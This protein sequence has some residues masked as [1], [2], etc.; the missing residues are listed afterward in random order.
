MPQNNR[1]D[2]SARAARWRRGWGRVGFRP[3]LEGLEARVA[4]ADGGLDPSFGDGGKL[5]LDLGDAAAS[6]QA[7]AVQQ[8]GK[9]VVAGN[10]TRSGGIFLSRLE[11]DGTPDLSF[12]AG[13]TRTLDS[14]DFRSATV[15]TVLLQADG[16]IVVVGSSSTG[17]GLIGATRTVVAARFSRSGA[18]DPTFGVGGMVALALDDLATVGGAT[19]QDDGKI[20]IAGQVRVSGNNAHATDTVVVRLNAN[21]SLDPSFDDDG[22]RVVDYGI[23][24]TAAAVLVQRDGK[25]VVG[26]SVREPGVFLGGGTNSIA[27]A[28]LGP[29]GA[30]DPSFSGDGLLVIEETANSMSGSSATGL[31]LQGD[32]KILVA[33]VSKGPSSSIQSAFTA[34]RVLGDGRLDRSFSGDGIQ[35]VEFSGFNPTPT[36]LAIQG[37][38]RI[39]L[40]GYTS[41]A[42]LGALGGDFAVARLTANGQLDSSFHEDG[43]QT[44]AFDLSP[45]LGSTNSEDAGQA[46]AIQPD[47]R[48][49]LAGY[50]TVQANAQAALARLLSAA[51]NVPTPTPPPPNPPTPPPPP[52]PPP[53]PPGGTLPGP[54]GLGT[55]GSLYGGDY[56]GDGLPDLAL[57]SLDDSGTGRFHLRLST[58]GG[59]RVGVLGRA[60]D[61][62]VVGDFDGDGKSDL[63][64]FDSLYDGDGD[65][66]AESGA[67]KIIASMT[68]E[69]VVIPFGAPGELDRPAPADYDGDGVTDL[70]V[71]RPESDLIPGAAEWFVRRSRD[72]ALRVQFGAAAGVDLPVPADYDGDG[73]AD[74]ATFRPVPHPLDVQQGAAQWF[75][76]PSAPNPGWV[77]TRGAFATAF[78]A[79]SGTDQP[80]VADFDGDGRA[81]IAAFRSVSD[82][83]SGR[84][85]WFILPA[86]SGPNGG[87]R[88]TFGD[89]GAL[90]APAD[91]DGDGV[92]ELAIHDP[93]TGRWR[94]RSLSSAVDRPL[95]FGTAG[96]VVVPVLSPLASRLLATERDRG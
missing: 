79:P 34:L 50:A 96:R 38:G 75:V 29:S 59:T 62:P 28:R 33:G 51:P 18:P 67:W 60:G 71:F 5:L 86:A 19:L 7:L 20:V 13:G 94:F 91:Y 2:R 85:D 43:K 11:P 55:D 69:L 35:H 53:S 1:R 26:G 15:S 46:L 41:I 42:P 3:V 8:D 70:A 39:V 64:V 56:D 93:T 87:V 9:V 37:D 63:A 65:G 36:G 48:I 17:G 81:D 10:F 27:L 73:I 54:F 78:G 16:R 32:G 40:G 57:F 58:T 12:A 66:E 47:G 68:G 31:A 82:L 80:V 44:V 45:M 90:A 89:A 24:S 84:A 25:I 49:V 83:A 52:I 72:G 76:L 74:L 92:A 95:S 14:G 6:A 30:L 61:V 77:T 23:Q 4:L 22:V 88:V 21:G